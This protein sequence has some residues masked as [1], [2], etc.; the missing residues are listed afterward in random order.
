MLRFLA[1][2]NFPFPS[3]KLLRENGYFINSISEGF[4]G[5]SDEVVLQIAVEED[6]IILTFDKDYGELL[7]KYQKEFPPAVIFFRL[8]GSY[9]DTAGKIL[10]E[11]LA[12]KSIHIKNHFTVIDNIGIRQRKLI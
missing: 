10:L 11:L 8:K 1:N 12:N 9:P 7:Y 4:K 6:L 5:I 2:E 3:V